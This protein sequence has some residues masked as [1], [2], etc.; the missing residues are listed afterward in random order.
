M[1]CVICDGN[2][3]Y[4]CHIQRIKGRPN[5]STTKVDVG[6]LKIAELWVKK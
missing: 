4:Y 3:M 5:I 6:A 1:I 2:E